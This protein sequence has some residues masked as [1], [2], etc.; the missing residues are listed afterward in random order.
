MKIDRGSTWNKWDFHIH[1]PFSLLNNLYGFNPYNNPSQFDDYV[2]KLFTAATNNNIVAIGIT[3]YFSIE[4]YKLIRNNYL[5]NDTKL[6]EL[7]P[8]EHLIERIKNIFVFPNVELRIDTFVGDKSINYHVIFS[9]EISVNDIEENFLHRLTIKQTDNFILPLNY[10]S[11]E[12]IG[13]DFKSYNNTEKRQDY[14][15][16]LEKITVNND[17]VKQALKECQNFKEKYLIS[18]PVDEDLS[19]VNWNGRDYQIKKNIY[20]ESDLL[21]TSSANTRNWALAKGHEREQ[22]SEFGSIKPC[23]WGSDAH[24]YEKMFCPS[25]DKYCWIKADNTFDGLKQILYEPDERVIIQKECPENKDEHKIINSI[26]FENTDFQK[27]PIY[28]NDG[29][30]AIIGGKSTGKSILLRSLAN[31]IDPKQVEERCP[32]SNSFFNIQAKVDWKDGAAG[33][34]EIIY[35]P[36]S[37]LNKITENNSVDSQLNSII[38]DFLKQDNKISEGKNELDNKIISINAK[39]QHSIFEYISALSKNK[40]NEYKL[41]VHG[42]KEAFQS[43]IDSLEKQKNEYIKTVNFTSEKLQ[44]YTKLSN[45]IG[46]LNQ[47]LQ[48]L[49]RNLQITNKLSSPY[50]YIQ[51]ITTVNYEG[52][53][54]YNLDNIFASSDEINSFISELNKIVSEKWESKINSIND[55]RRKEIFETKLELEKYNSEIKPLEELISTSEKLSQIENQLQ[56]EKEKCKIAIEI[57]NSIVKN[58]ELM[59]NLKNQIFSFTLEQ[60]NTYKKLIEIIT[61]NDFNGT[62]LDF[63]AEISFKI[64]DFIECIYS[65]FDNRNFPT[66]KDKYHYNLNEIDSFQ[67]DNEFYNSIW[68]A[69]NNGILTFKAGNSIQTALERIFSD[70]N[71]INFVIKSDNESI[72]IMSPGKKALVLLEIIINLT[73]SKCPIL[74]DQPED[75]LDNRSIYTDLV[76]YLKT[77][78]YERQIII[79]THNANLV[80]GADAEEVIIANQDGNEAKNNSK[81]F[82]YR[83]GAI[84]NTKPVY[85]NAGELLPGILNKKGIQE[86]ICDI[87]EGGKEAFE[88]RMKKYM[89]I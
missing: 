84:E 31:I 54:E 11:I 2:K 36:Q 46:E 28:F 65:L 6:Y 1:T 13:K 68:E 26:T 72:D 34:R 35:I 21:M 18:V 3:D 15:V 60:T 64:K 76:K 16:G 27:E 74:I 75:D 57:E 14:I 45:K 8:D 39:L 61:D 17:E 71:Y 42:H 41:N 85:N 63:K 22:I 20:R 67:I 49:E 4:G 87:L 44:E 69:M 80:I 70:W 88:L 48:S 55:S 12:I 82:E 7:F 23:I 78:K 79:V 59:E 29:L 73:K 66:F 43:T 33:E 81:R 30:T 86:Q 25:G 5:S 83:S 19:S 56:D 24:A 58:N 52:E 53:P 89:E 47:N 32:K 50:V 40:E 62:S 10:N 77:K 37:W 38:W 9:D 51:D